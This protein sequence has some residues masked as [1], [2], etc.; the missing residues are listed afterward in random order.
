MRFK[1]FHSSMHC[2]TN[3]FHFLL[4]FFIE[5]IFGAPT[6]TV[7][8]MIS[9][10]ASIALRGSGAGKSAIVT[11]VSRRIVSTLCEYIDGSHNWS[12][13]KI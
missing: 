12:A 11:P 3:A 7:I 1:L 8:F 5:T 6:A 10:K 13:E 2:V 9:S 4:N